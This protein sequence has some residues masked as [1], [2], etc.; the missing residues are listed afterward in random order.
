[1]P[2]FIVNGVTVKRENIESQYGM[3]KS[4]D[5]TLQEYGTNTPIVA[6]WYTKQDS[7]L[8]AVGATFDGDV[9][10]S[11]YGLKIKRA[12]KGGGRRRGRGDVAGARGARSSR[13]HAA[14]PPR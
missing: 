1:M 14:R 6:N 7:P 8:P 12:Q 4:V 2:Q 10:Q 11:E 13:Q 5:L 9:S 3:F